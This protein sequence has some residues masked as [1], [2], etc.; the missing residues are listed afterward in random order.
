MH[1]NLMV[2][3]VQVCFAHFYSKSIPQV[4]YE[5]F[6]AILIIQLV[7]HLCLVLFVYV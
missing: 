1:K 5:P 7:H 3:F 2:V 4:S 6:C